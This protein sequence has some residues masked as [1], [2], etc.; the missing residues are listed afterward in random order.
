MPRCA[1]ATTA[2]THQPQPH[3]QPFQMSAVTRRLAKRRWSMLS[4]AMPKLHLWLL[5]ESFGKVVSTGTWPAQKRMPIARG[6][7]S[8]SPFLSRFGTSIVGANSTWRRHRGEACHISNS[9]CCC[10]CCCC[11]FCFCFC[12]AALQNF[13]NGNIVWTCC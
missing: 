6:R 8:S 9:S 1:A 10:C 12:S 7:T 4:A 11:C 2:A 13:R 5:R 3:H